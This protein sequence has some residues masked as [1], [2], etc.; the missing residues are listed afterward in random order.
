M[1]DKYGP[2]SKDTK[3]CSQEEFFFFKEPKKITNNSK[4]TNITPDSEL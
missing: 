4:Q 3:S 1:R 2:L